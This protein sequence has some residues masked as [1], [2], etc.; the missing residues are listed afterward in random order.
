MVNGGED[1]IP[2]VDLANQTIAG[3]RVSFRDLRNDLAAQHNIEEALSKL[4][5][6]FE[7]VIKKSN[8]KKEEG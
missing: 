2:I 5:L 7:Y 1:T 4:Q 6:N 3:V 8:V